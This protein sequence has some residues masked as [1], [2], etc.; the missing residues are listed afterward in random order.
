MNCLDHW[1]IVS[2]PFALNSTMAAD[3]FPNEELFHA[4][5]LWGAGAKHRQA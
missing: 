3:K 5:P 1:T 2:R 4:A